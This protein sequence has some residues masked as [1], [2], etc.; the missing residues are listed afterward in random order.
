MILERLRRRL[1]D[2]PVSVKLLAGFGLVV[3]L[4]VLLSLAAFA[5]E[6]AN[7]S[8]GSEVTQTITVI[9]DSNTALAALLDMETSYRGYLLAGRPEFLDPY[10]AGQIVYRNALAKLVDETADNPDQMTRWQR[11]GM[12]AETWQQQV[13]EPGIALRREVDAGRADRAAID[14]LVGTGE[15]R[16]QFDAIREVFTAAN[17][18]EDRLLEQRT[19]QASAANQ[20]LLVTLGAGTLLALAIGLAAGLLLTRDIT[21]ASGRLALAAEQIASGDLH[22]RV[23][24]HRRDELGRSAEAF[25]RMADRLE[26]SITRLEDSEQLLREQTMEFER[27]NRELQEFASVASHDLQEPLRKVRA[28]GDRLAAH[29]G[30]GLSPRGQDYL[31]R[32]QD[33]AGRMQTLISDLL[34]LSRVTTRGQPFTAIDLHHIAEQVIGDLEE[35]IVQADGQVHLGPLPTIEADPTQMRQLLQNL[36]GN[37]LKFH[38][39]GVPPIVNVTATI[40]GGDESDETDEARLQLAVVDNGIGF[41]EK[42]L[43]RIFTTF[44]RL[45]GRTEYEGTGIG[46]AVCRRIAERHNGSIT[47]YSTVNEGSTFLVDLPVRQARTDRTDVSEAEAA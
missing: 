6:R 46:L 15:G 19:T 38:R 31:A 37:A 45:H 22:Q 33:A 42:Y 23:G 11:I 5:N 35:R 2:T 34:A 43:D 40:L 29:E 41:D 7:E 3:S 8:A 10:T 32:M 4:L 26:G 9:S 1:A 44:Q 20:S 39:P 16:R 28:F 27:S 14:Q 21:D 25:D 13:T 18:E 36:L 47:A 24:L 30:P 17:A 12:L